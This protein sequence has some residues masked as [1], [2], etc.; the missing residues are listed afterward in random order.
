MKP[1]SPLSLFL[2]INLTTASPIPLCS[3]ECQI[4]LKFIH[5]NTPP[6]R[7][8]SEPYFPTHQQPP[9][10]LSEEI[11]NHA[12][13][14]SE[15]EVLAPSL[16][17]KVEKPLSS[18]FLLSI[19]ASKPRLQKSPVEAEVENAAAAAKPTSTL[20][21][22][23]KEDLKRYWAALKDEK[24]MKEEQERQEREKVLG[25]KGCGHGKF[26]GHFY[27]QKT[28]YVREYSDVIVVGLVLLF[29][30]GV[31][32]AEVFEKFGKKGRGA[33]YLADDEEMVVDVSECTME[34]RD[35]KEERKEVDSTD[36]K[37]GSEELEHDAKS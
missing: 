26:D 25:I 9:Q 1:I 14:P 7:L 12:H 21:E 3:K 30:M 15:T 33:I 5:R 10:I 28:E 31:V 11:N 6:A 23:R 8:S 27:M 18:K 2:F 37:N 20:P 35:E 17:L 13:T 4:L 16:V 19:S 32:G 29:L 36:L 22:S 24:T 34:Y